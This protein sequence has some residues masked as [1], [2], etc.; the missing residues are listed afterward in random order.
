MSVQPSLTKSSSCMLPATILPKFSMRFC[1]QPGSSDMAHSGSVGRLPLTS[2]D[3]GVRWK[4]NR[5]WA[6]S[7][8]WGMH[9]TAV[10]PVPI[11]PTTLSDSSFRP[12]LVSPPV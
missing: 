8:T 3:D 10:A 4:T 6:A 5:C 7:P 12:P 11:T 9:C 2:M 1:C